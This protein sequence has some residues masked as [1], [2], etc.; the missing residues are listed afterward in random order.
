MTTADA[1]DTPS[2]TAKGFATRE[3]ILRSAAE[4]LLSEGVSG[5]NL[6]KVRQ[7]ASVSGSQL[8]HY[9][10]DRNDLIRAVV[11]RQIEMVLDFHRQPKVGGLYTFEDW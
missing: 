1:S 6:E 5:F 8:D 11:K 9:F 3:R 4:V 2:F 7:A 10:V